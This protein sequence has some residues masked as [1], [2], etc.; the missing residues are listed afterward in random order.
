MDSGT[1]APVVLVARLAR[2]GSLLARLGRLLAHL[3]ARLGRL[4]DRLLDRRGRLPA[5]ARTNA[6]FLRQ[7]GPRILLEDRAIAS[8]SGR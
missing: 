8:G 1:S 3:L 6:G 7:R 4:L 2:L 5:P